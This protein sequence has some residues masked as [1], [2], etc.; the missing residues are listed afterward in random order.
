MESSALNAFNKAPSPAV[1]LNSSDNENHADSRSDNTQN[2]VEAA[3]Y[4]SLQKI[5]RITSSS[6]SRRDNEFKPEE[7]AQRVLSKVSDAIEASAASAVEKQSLIAQAREG[8]YQ[9]YK[10]ARNVLES[11]GEL[12]HDL[13][14][15]LKE[16]KK[17]IY[18]GLDQLAEN[19][20]NQPDN[21]PQKQTLSRSQTNSITASSQ[22][23]RQASIQITTQQGDIVNI[24]INSSSSANFSQVSGSNDAG[25]FLN[26]QQSNQNHFDFSF[27][28]EGDLNADE[29]NAISN[30]LEDITKLAKKFFNGD[31]QEA[32]NKAAELNIDGDELAAF[33]VDLNFSQQTEVISTYQ[34]IA[35]TQSQTESPVPSIAD[36]VNYASE[37]DQLINN[38]ETQAP[39]QN[40]R[41]ATL[42]IF[43]L[44]I[45][46][47]QSTQQTYVNDSTSLLQQLLENLR[48]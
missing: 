29:Q 3:L 23:S 18:K 27:S 15:D 5:G 19:L 33:S 11:R 20:S 17:L 22:T 34:D 42:D 24:D 35:N 26:A 44:L 6:P 9:G 25:S 41:A 47:Q 21:T 7:V 1:V 10:D 28:L 30:L 43:Q 4:S 36:A 13:K 48:S 2:T 32:F 8:V 38:T 46:Q 37:L 45:E 40:N 16:T 39:L 14:H 12:T 31:V